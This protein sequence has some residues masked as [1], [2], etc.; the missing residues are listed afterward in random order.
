MDSDTGAIKDRSEE[1]GALIRYLTARGEGLAFAFEELFMHAGI[2][3]GRNAHS[4]EITYEQAAFRT[5][6]A[7][8]DIYMHSG[9]WSLVDAMKFC[10]GNAPHGE[11]LD[12]SLH[13]WQELDTTLRRVGH[14]LLMVIGKVQFMK[15]FRDRANQLGD[16]FV[17]KDFIDGVYAVGLILWSLIRWEI[18]GFDNEINTLR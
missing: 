12:G 4:R 13:L 14:H 5:V 10:V 15:L 7:L 17:S 16:E 2:L 3:D 18:T 6:R 9:D 11:L 8:S 1:V